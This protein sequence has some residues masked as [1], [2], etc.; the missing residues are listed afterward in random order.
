[1]QSSKYGGGKYGEAKLALMALLQ[2]WKDEGE[3]EECGGPAEVFHHPDPSTKLFN[4]GAGTRSFD[5]MLAE[6]EKCKFLCH[7]C[8]TRLHK[9]KLTDEQVRAIKSDPRTQ[10]VI[11]RDYGIDQKL[12]WNIKHGVNWSDIK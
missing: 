9:R 2:E 4:V 1:M 7:K 3:C 12:V 10:R 6:I 5:N 8:H 11:A